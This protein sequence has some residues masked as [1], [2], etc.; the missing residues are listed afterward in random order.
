MT[1][2][3]CDILDQLTPRS[4]SFTGTAACSK[5]EKRNL[6]PM[7]Q[8]HLTSYSTAFLSIP[9][10]SICLCFSNFRHLIRITD[11]GLLFSY[12]DAPLFDISIEEFETAAID[13][14]RILAEIESSAA[15]NRT[16]DELK[17]VTNAQCAKYLP[18]NSNTAKNNDIESER[19]KDHLGHFILR[20][21]FCRSYVVLV[22]PS[23]TFYIDE[24]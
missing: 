11:E 17:T 1:K 7:I 9:L 4:T 15:R 5:A 24:F 18:L 6:L 23:L 12:D 2:R 22:A 8:A 14:L 21:A 16:W 20:L 3:V 19:R 13:R 10:D